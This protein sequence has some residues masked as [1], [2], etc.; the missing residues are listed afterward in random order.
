M[1]ARGYV[2]ERASLIYIFCNLPY[3]E[4]L[5]TITQVF[6]PPLHMNSR[7]CYYDCPTP[8]YNGSSHSNYVRSAAV[9]MSTTN[10]YTTRHRTLIQTCLIY[11]YMY[12]CHNSLYF[13]SQHVSLPL[14]YKHW[15]PPNL[16]FRSLSW[17]SRQT[18]LNLAAQQYPVRV[19]E[20]SW[21]NYRLVWQNY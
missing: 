10:T 21:L 4:Q 17:G 8:L 9:I 5:R 2:C 7:H 16:T 19:T 12:L 1:S 3:V 6:L 14:S 20:G 11:L 15:A 13:I 18:L